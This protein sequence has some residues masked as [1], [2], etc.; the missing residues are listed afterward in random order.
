MG[1]SRG[2]SA[3]TKVFEDYLKLNIPLTVY[4][5]F[6]KFTRGAENFSLLIGNDW[7]IKFCLP[8]LIDFVDMRQLIIK[9]INNSEVSDNVEN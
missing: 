7:V 8:S 1:V 9:H 5:L 3:N 6:E 4:I 2:T